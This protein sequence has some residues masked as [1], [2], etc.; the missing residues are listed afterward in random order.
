MTQLEEVK[1]R[2]EAMLRAADERIREERA[3][4]EKLRA[5]IG[6]NQTQISGL[7]A[8]LQEAQAVQSASAEKDD[9]SRTL[10][11]SASKSSIRSKSEGS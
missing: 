5:E 11:D 6:S 7:T 9:K 2:H 3:A 8:M 1:V 10:E 4:A